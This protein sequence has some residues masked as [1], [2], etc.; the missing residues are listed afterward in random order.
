VAADPSRSPYPTG[1]GED[2]VVGPVDRVAARPVGDPAPDVDV[3][4]AGEADAGHG[5]LGAVHEVIGPHARHELVSS[6]MRSVSKHGSCLNVALYPT[7][8]D[9]GPSASAL[10]PDLSGPCVPGEERD[11]AAPGDDPPRCRAR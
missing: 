6:P 4:A 10:E 8:V 5:V 9:A 2:P 7:M 1:I 11:V 3:A